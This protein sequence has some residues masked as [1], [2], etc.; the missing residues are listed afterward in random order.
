MSHHITP[1][2]SLSYDI[3]VIIVIMVTMAIIMVIMMM[4]ITMM[5]KFEDDL[6]RCSHLLLPSF[7]LDRQSLLPG[8][9]LIGLIIKLSKQI[10]LVA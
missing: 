2:N 5:I 7:S 8:R 10:N 4:M 6:S 1:H 3:M 9:L